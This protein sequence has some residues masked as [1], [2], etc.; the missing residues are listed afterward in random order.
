MS[1]DDIEAQSTAEIQTER[2]LRKMEDVVNG[3][4]A[5]HGCMAGRRMLARGEQMKE[6][7]KER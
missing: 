3:H 6:T 1:K 2:N 7:K 4:A 5:M